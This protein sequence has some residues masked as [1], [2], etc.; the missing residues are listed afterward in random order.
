MAKKELTAAQVRGN[1]AS[2]AYT[3]RDALTL[4]VES[5]GNKQWVQRITINGKQ[6]SIGLGSF[7]AVGLADARQAAAGNRRAV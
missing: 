5:S 4:R 1:L 3:D 6:A 7:P 2:G